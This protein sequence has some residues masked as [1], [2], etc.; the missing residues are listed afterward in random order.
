MFYLEAKG[1]AETACFKIPDIKNKICTLPAPPPTAIIGLLGRSQDLPYDK[2]IEKFKDL[3]L[4]INFKYKDKFNDLL[5]YY[6]YQGTSKNSKSGTPD[7]LKKEYLQDCELVLILSSESKDLLDELKESLIN[8]LNT[9]YLGNSKSMFMFNSCEYIESNP[10]RSKTLSNTV[11]EGN[12]LGKFT[13]SENALRGVEIHLLP[14]KYEV[15][16]SGYRKVVEKK[17]YTFIRD[18]I[19]LN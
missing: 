19:I 17:T 15:L 7:V 11:V 2:T 13:Y 8:P 3:G 9:L 16:P 6:K 18:E 1:F 10:D 5:K 4:D 12:L 14:S